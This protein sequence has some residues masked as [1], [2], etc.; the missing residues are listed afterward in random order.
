MNFLLI[1]YRGTGK[2]TIAQALADQLKWQWVDA[3]VELERQAGMTI[4]QMF[5]SQ[6][7]PA[8]RDL[9]AK[10]L[11]EL[12]GRPKIV[13]AT[14][15]GVVTREENRLALKQSTAW[16]VW[17]KASVETIVARISAD[18]STAAR[19]PSLTQSPVAAEVAHLLQQREP[20]Y[21]ECSHWEMDTEGKP[22]HLLAAEILARLPV[23]FA[24][25]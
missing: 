2:T 7:E 17:L 20:W 25:L 12:L 15:G 1:G 3:D 16:V 21:R 9:E 13:L 10:V 4:K 19:R 18:T 14:G 24:E 8:F 22:P 11:R 23:S 6:G 5:E